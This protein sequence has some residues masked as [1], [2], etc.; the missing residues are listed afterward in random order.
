MVMHVSHSL[1][2]ANAWTRNFLEDQKKAK[3]FAARTHSTWMQ[4]PNGEVFYE[5]IGYDEQYNHLQNV[6][7]EKAKSVQDT[8]C[9]APGGWGGGSKWEL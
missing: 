6:W 5:G 2:D 1:D 7:A 3:K 9:A 4:E 8:V